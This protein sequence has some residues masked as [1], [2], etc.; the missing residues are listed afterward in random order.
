MM[1]R[2]Y[3]AGTAL[4][5]KLPYTHPTKDPRE[6]NTLSYHFLK[7]R[8]KDFF[9]VPDFL[10]LQ[11]DEGELQVSVGFK[12]EVKR[13]YRD[14]GVVLVDSKLKDILDDDNA[15]LN[16][17][18]AKHKG[19]SMW[20]EYLKSIAQ[21]HYTAVDETKS[22]GG[23]P[24]AAKGLTKYALNALNLEDPAD[25]VGTI[26]RAKEGQTSSA[27]NDKKIADLTALVH[28]LKGALDAKGK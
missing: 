7:A 2:F 3:N 10:T 8:E 6:G 19:D 16:D 13:L 15:A 24:R 27:E 22:F 17:K 9:E 18:D 20:R 21:A 23:V 28:Q 14:R 4:D 25:S 26:T 12:R 1:A 11:T 5:E